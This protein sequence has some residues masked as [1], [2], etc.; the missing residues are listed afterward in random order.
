VAISTSSW[1]IETQFMAEARNLVFELRHDGEMIGV[2]ERVSSVLEG[3]QELQ[4]FVK[5]I[6]HLVGR[7]A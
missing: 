2:G 1:V 3:S 7:P 6:A 4:R 5:V